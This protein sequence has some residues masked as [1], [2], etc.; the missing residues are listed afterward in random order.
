MRNL[1]TSISSSSA[2]VWVWSVMSSATELLSVRLAARGERSRS[3]AEEAS[4]YGRVSVGKGW[5]LADRG[6]IAE[7]IGVCMNRSGSSRST[8]GRLGSD[9]GPHGSSAGHLEVCWVSRLRERLRLERGG[10]CLGSRDRLLLSLSLTLSAEDRNSKRP[11]AR[12]C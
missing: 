9:M 8:L 3:K 12:N 7:R 1:A 11:C 10:G 2:L 4:W 6:E 5:K